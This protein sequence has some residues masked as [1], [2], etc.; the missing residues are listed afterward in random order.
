MVLTILLDVLAGILVLLGVVLSVVN[1]PGVWVIFG[2]YVLA[3]FADGKE[4]FKLWIILVVLGIC[5][6]ASV[7]DNIMT[8]AIAKKYGATKW[9][10]VGSFVGSILGLLIFNWIGML[11]GLFV[12]ALA[13]EVIILR[14]ALKESA[15]SGAAAVIGWFVGVLL[16]MIVALGLGIWWVILV[17]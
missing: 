10:L 16:K 11:V 1:L 17:L 14:R 6:V 7:L 5:I 15:K 3:Y 13:V 4:G 2:G 12:G 8:Y 9:G